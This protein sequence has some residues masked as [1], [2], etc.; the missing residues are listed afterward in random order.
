MRILTVC[1]LF[2][3]MS[4]QAGEPG[5][6]M[7]PGKVSLSTPPMEE[8]KTMSV[9]EWQQGVPIVRE[10]PISTDLR[11]DSHSVGTYQQVPTIEYREPVYQEPVYLPSAQPEK[12]WKDKLWNCVGA[13]FRYAGRVVSTVGRE[14]AQVVTASGDATVNIARE[15]TGVK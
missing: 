8:P 13:P 12:T 5:L 4:V 3:C 11:T 10:E 2:L 1:L 6:A 9:I 15:T 7:Q 14:A